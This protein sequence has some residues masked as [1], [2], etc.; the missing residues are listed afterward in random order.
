VCF[1]LSPLARCASVTCCMFPSLALFF[2]YN[3]AFPLDSS[4]KNP[5]C[6]QQPHPISCFHLSRHFHDVCFHLSTCTQHSIPLPRTIQKCH[7]LISLYLT[8]SSL[9]APGAFCHFHLIFFLALMRHVLVSLSLVSSRARLPSVHARLRVCS[10]SLDV[11]ALAPLEVIIQA[12]LKS[13]TNTKTLRLQK[14]HRRMQ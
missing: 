9:P 4:S 13:S 12:N 2:P 3:F 7:H 14:A 5:G 8:H 10:G 1:S 11:M 6:S